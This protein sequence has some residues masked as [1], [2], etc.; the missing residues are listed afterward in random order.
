MVQNVNTIQTEYLKQVRMCLVSFIINTY[1]YH[2][3]TN[4][5]HVTK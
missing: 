4:S 1:Q 2:Q 5:L 3:Y